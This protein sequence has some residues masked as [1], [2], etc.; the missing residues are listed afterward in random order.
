MGEQRRQ[1]EFRVR[2]EGYESARGGVCG[3]VKGRDCPAS[4]VG[5]RKEEEV[6]ALAASVVGKREEEE[7][8]E[9]TAEVL[10]H[11][12]SF[13]CLCCSTEETGWL[14]N[15]NTIRHSLATCIAF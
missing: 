7:E 8:E 3:G 5:K 9:E 10:Q 6:E 4:V 12:R 15:R 2:D 13:T 14:G 1:E 11:F